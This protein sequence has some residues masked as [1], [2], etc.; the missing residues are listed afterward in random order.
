MLFPFGV[1]GP[2]Q[3]GLSQEFAFEALNVIPTAAG[4][5]PFPGFGVTTSAITARAQGAITVRDLAGNIF[6]FCGDAT[7]LY[8]QHSDGLSWDDV[9]RTVGGAYAAPAAGWWYFWQFGTYVFAT[10]GVDALQSF[11][12]AS[13]TNFAAA[14][15]TPPVA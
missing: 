15:G 3:Q 9:S 5:R 8:R 14:S 7:K 11:N 6:N 2:D 4:Y 13:S 10:N 1:Y 12:L